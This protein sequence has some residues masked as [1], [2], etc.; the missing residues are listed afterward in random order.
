LT[1]G[2][3]YYIKVQDWSSSG[4]ASTYTFTICVVSNPATAPVNDECATATLLTPS[5]MCNPT[6][7]TLA[8]AT[9]STITTSCSGSKDVFY[10]FV[11][12]ATTA[13]VNVTGSSGL[14][15]EVATFAACAEQVFHV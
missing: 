7:G 15:V 3:T 8:N 9:T 12:D 14:D 2:N 4:S 5:T 1:I 13:T 11:A 10:K 6:S